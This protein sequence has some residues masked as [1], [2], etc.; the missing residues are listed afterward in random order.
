VNNK[1]S[2]NII[3]FLGGARSEKSALAE[4][5][6]AHFSKVLYFA[7]ANVTSSDS[8][9]E[10]RVR[11]HVERRPKSWLTLEPPSKVSDILKTV[12]E[13][14]VEAVLFDCATLWLSS[15]VCDNLK[16][17]NL[18]EDAIGR[19]ERLIETLSEIPCPVFI[20][21]NET[22]LGV[23]PE[24]RLSRQFRDL[25][26]TL[27]AKLLNSSKYTLMSLAGKP[28]LL[29]DETS[30]ADYRELAVVTDEWIVK[31]LK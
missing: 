13:N 24:N 30:D 4:K 17:D 7:T 23:V 31:D 12:K 11:L 9:L 5:C 14:A 20:V 18:E 2:S 6:A 10:K 8:E 25:Q 15:I 1:K 26:G 27:N 16:P 3:L 29:H 21:S 22:G 28:I 19:I